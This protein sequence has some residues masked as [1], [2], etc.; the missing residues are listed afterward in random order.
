MPRPR[1]PLGRNRPFPRTP[2]R[3]GIAGDAEIHVKKGCPWRRK[4]MPGVIRDLQEGRKAYVRG[5]TA[6]TAVHQFGLELH[7]LVEGRDSH[8]QLAILHYLLSRA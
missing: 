1:S 8:G 3:V 6:A 7:Y 5:V 2:D 4:V